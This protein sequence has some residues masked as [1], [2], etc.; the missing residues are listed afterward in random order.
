MQYR[1]LFVFRLA[2][3]RNYLIMVRNATD[4]LLIQG[5]GIHI[6]EAAHI[7]FGDTGHQIFLD[8]ILDPV[9]FSNNKIQLEILLCERRHPNTK[10]RTSSVLDPPIQCRVTQNG[11]VV[12]TESLGLLFSFLLNIRKLRYLLKKCPHKILFYYR[13]ITAQ[14]CAIRSFLSQKSEA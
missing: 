11:A 9:T 8:W 12:V 6:E 5:G 13:K 7:S 4:K 14:S 3:L 1:L 2:R 10:C